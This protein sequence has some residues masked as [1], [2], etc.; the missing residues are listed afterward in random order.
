MVLVDESTAGDDDLN[1]PKHKIIHTAHLETMYHRFLGMRSS[2]FYSTNGRL[3]SIVRRDKIACLWHPHAQAHTHACTNIC[4]QLYWS[5]MKQ[6]AG[7]VTR[8]CSAR[9]INS[10]FRPSRR[11]EKCSFKSCR[12][13]LGKFA[14]GPPGPS[15]SIIE[16]RTKSTSKP[17]C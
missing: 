12:F 6:L 10:H 16:Y 4:A 9:S 7:I 3:S 11:M 2:T 17:H 8:K 15:D 5:L 13:S 14:L 1:S